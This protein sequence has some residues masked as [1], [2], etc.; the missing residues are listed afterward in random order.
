MPNKAS[1]IAHAIPKPGTIEEK[2]G[3]LKAAELCFG[4]EVTT[5]PDLRQDLH[6]YTKV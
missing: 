3:S 6:V 4:I 1:Y 5:Y 2:V